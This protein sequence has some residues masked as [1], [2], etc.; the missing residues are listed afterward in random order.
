MKE[1]GKKILALIPLNLDG[2]VFAWQDG[3]ADEIRRCLAANFTDWE[4]DNEKFQE[5]VQRVTRALRTDDGGREH[6]PKPLI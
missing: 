4:R 6:P 5:Q 3:K 1:R 2:Q